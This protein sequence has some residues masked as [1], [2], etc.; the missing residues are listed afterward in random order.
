MDEDRFARV[1][2]RI[3]PMPRP[4]SP[5][6]DRL[7]TWLECDRTPENYY[8]LLGE[9]LFTDRLDVLL[10][11]VNSTSKSLHQRQNHKLEKVVAR[12]RSLELMCAKAARTFSTDDA[13]QA[14]DQK[15]L[16]RLR[17]DYATQRPASGSVP[18][19]RQW[20]VSSRNVAQHRL[21]EI[22]RLLSPPSAAA[23]SADESGPSAVVIPSAEFAWNGSSTDHGTLTVEAAEKS[24]TAAYRSPALKLPFRISHYEV[25]EPLGSG[26]IGFVYKARHV[27]L[28]KLFAIKLLRND[29]QVEDTSIARFQREMVAIGKLN[30]AN[31]VRATD[32]GCEADTFFLVME[33]I[34]GHNLHDVVRSR[35]PLPVTEACDLIRQTALGLEH[36]H[37]Q[38]LV[39]RDIKPSNLMLT[40]D[41]AVKI[42]DL[43][44]ALLG[45]SVLSWNHGPGDPDAELTA[46]GTIVGTIDFMAPEQLNG[47]R[48]MDARADIYSLGCTLFYLLTGQ[49]VFRECGSDLFL[50]MAAHS[51]QPVPRLSLYRSGVPEA[52]EQILQRMLAKSPQDRFQS[53]R[54]VVAALE[55]VI[56]NASRSAGESHTSPF[57][58]DALGAAGTPRRPPAQSPPTPPPMRRPA[59]ANSTAVAAVTAS[60]SAARRASDPALNTTQQVSV[61]APMPKP[62][63]LPQRPKANPGTVAVKPATDQPSIRV[64][65][66]PL[67]TTDLVIWCVTGAFLAISLAGGLWLMLARLLTDGRR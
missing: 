10:S 59:A 28:Q 50:R 67:N 58:G 1:T 27:Q 18:D 16:E 19:L 14:Y 12:A 5:T 38:G 29:R 48:G 55:P 57:S 46:V 22:V 47:R 36:A 40:R 17:D 33:L 41:G 45:P 65:R 26:G 43:G 15:L 11:A 35:G 62:P 64:V 54:E 13:W 52:L 51:C 63:R 7:R 21:E 39:H 3:G 31:I 32:A 20:L 30:H 61:T 42:L 44:L 25:F 66:R 53:A 37:E 60:Q 9:P 24:R 6:V 4:W 34:D 56:A 23:G 2:F 49:V 8:E